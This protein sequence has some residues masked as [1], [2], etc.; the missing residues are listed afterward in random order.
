MGKK[1][2]SLC[3][4]VKDEAEQLAGALASVA[5]VVD[6]MIVVD[7][8]STDGTQAVAR[9]L[10]A[11]VSEL[12]W[13]DDFSAARNTALAEATGDWV[14]ILDADERI[15]E[16]D[17]P[18]IR[19]AANSLGERAYRFTQ[20]SYTNNSAL[21]DWRACEE[22][23]GEGEGFSGYVEASQVRLFP[24]RPQ[25]RYAG[26]VHETLVPACEAMQLSVVEL[27]VAVH[28]YG[29]ARSAAHLRNKAQRY[30]ELGRRKLAES[31]DLEGAYELGTQL[32]ELHLNREAKEVFE[33]ILAR[34]PKQAKSR[35]MLGVACTAL[36]E[37][38]LA[39]RELSTVVHANPG[40]VDA[41]NNLGVAQARGGNLRAACDSLGKAVALDRE[42]ANALANLASAEAVL[43]R[44]E[45]ALAHLDEVAKLDPHGAGPRIRRAIVLAGCGAEDD[46]RAELRRLAVGGF[47][48][49]T[50]NVFHWCT[51]ATEL[52][53]EAE[54]DA[55]VESKLQVLQLD[56]EIALLLVSHFQA[57]DRDALAVLLLESILD[58]HPECAPALDALACYLARGGHHVEAMGLFVKA[59]RQEPR[60]PVYLRNVALCCEEMGAMREA[61]EFYGH[62]AACDPESAKHA[63]ERARLIE[64]LAM[65][66]TE[67]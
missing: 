20:L 64:D 35:N 36:G 17:H 16:R 8:G 32:L 15:A 21:V 62:L 1:R 63:L 59:L 42:N 30:L 47:H 12:E 2:I 5:A 41:W 27:D 49:D 7:T 39:A 50:S 45:S 26:P 44:T 18:I 34:S 11:K 58:A 65:A 28:H 48:F 23:R 9:G 55:F 14:L 37:L 29:R 46:A 4:I 25:L 24:N 3:M 22:D 33:R 56:Q 54:Y 13:P 52:E 19:A 31:G 66:G 53:M 38:D 57:N 6:E 60:N 61:L 43:G 67:H 10:G 51:L 40:F